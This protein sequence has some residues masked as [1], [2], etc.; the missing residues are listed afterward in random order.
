[1]KK[2]L[3]FVILL[4]LGVAITAMPALAAGTWG[5]VAGATNV[6]VLIGANNA[7][8]YQAA[9][10]GKP[11]FTVTQGESGALV[12]GGFVTLKLTGG[13]VF[14]ATQ[15]AVPTVAGGIAANG[16]LA[17]ADGG[18]AGYSYAKFVVTGSG[19][20]SG[21]TITFN[22]DTVSCLNVS[23]VGNNSNV[24]LTV[25]ITNPS[26]INTTTDNSFQASP[27]VYL[28]TGQN[29]FTIANANNAAYEDTADVLATSG[30]FTKFVN[31]TLTGRNTVFDT[32]T[33]TIAAG[34]S[35]PAAVINKK[36]MLVT[37]AG[38]FSG[39][40]K[41]TCENYTGAD[42]SGN[43]TGSAGLFSISADKKYAYAVYNNEFAGNGG[44]ALTINPKFYIDGTTTQLTRSFTLQFENL[45]DAPNYVATVWQ[46]SQVNYKILRNGVSFS[47]NSL[48]PL[49]T[50]KISDRSGNVTTGGSKVLITA[51][52]VNGAKLSEV[53]GAPTLLVQN[54]ETLQLTG[55]VIA[56]RFTG[57][58]ML[59]EFAVAS[60]TAVVTNV[61]KTAEGF[62][63]TV[64]TNTNGGI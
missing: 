59:Y 56:T 54:F 32:T 8:L 62:G 36:K 39:I 6:R 21:A 48:G 14:T 7:Q 17:F 49:N 41:V 58:P 10:N 46:S 30:P 22:P 35:I 4:I 15:M 37:L 60:T 47:A 33:P 50:I 3:I 1:M 9:A 42:S 24:D 55:D 51:Y 61:K 63:S 26:N 13:A 5:T 2:N 23:G 52:D 31:N 20:S 29:L 18:T 25:T 16:T 11:T 57:T 40:S 12:V 19:I 44:A 27:N 28:F 45:D 34:R 64:Y 53:A 38:D 43:V